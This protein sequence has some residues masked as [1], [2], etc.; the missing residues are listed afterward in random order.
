MQEQKGRSLDTRL[1]LLLHYFFGLQGETIKGFLGFLRSFRAWAFLLGRIALK[2][3]N[4]PLHSINSLYE[5]QRDGRHCYSGEQ[6]E[7]P[8]ISNMI[9][10]NLKH[11]ETR[12]GKRAT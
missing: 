11:C 3:A 5:Q 9:F 7:T 2:F 8:T 6:R 12:S 1:P 10:D 4:S